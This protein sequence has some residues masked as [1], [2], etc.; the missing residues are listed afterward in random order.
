MTSTNQ[1]SAIA[2]PQDPTSRTTPRCRSSSGQIWTRWSAPALI[3]KLWLQ[4]A[5]LSLQPNL[6]NLP[7][8]L[9]LLQLFLLREYHHLPNKRVLMS[10]CQ[11]GC[12]KSSAQL[13]H[14][15]SK[16]KW[17]GA[18]STTPVVLAAG[19]GRQFT[20]PGYDGVSNYAAEAKCLWT[21]APAAGAELTF[22]CSA[23]NIISTAAV[24]ER[25]AGE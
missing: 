8:L 13:L 1:G 24:G 19:E 10:L 6:P 15:Y 21:F 12:R 5:N 20:S 17:A 3:V 18:T 23:F 7:H 4:P 9:H 11:V 14:L 2:I 22:S 16:C 25:C